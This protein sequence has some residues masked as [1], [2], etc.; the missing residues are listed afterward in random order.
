MLAADQA[1]SLRRML[2]PRTTRRIAV[3]GCEPG[4]GATTVALGLASALAM[5]G[6]RVLLVDED[7]AG[8]RATR[9]A[10]AAPR[11]TLAQVL[12]GTMTAQEAAGQ[13]GTGAPEV[14][15]GDPG[16]GGS[17]AALQG[18]RT[19]LCDARAGADGSLSPFAGD[20]H[21]IVIV[22][23]PERASLTAAY[24]CIKRLHHQY[25][26]REFQLVVNGAAGEAGVEAVVGNLGRTASQYLGVQVRF[27]G[28]MP[29]DPL[30]ARGASLGRCV[31]E[32]FP[33]APATAVL[34]RIAAGI[35]AWPLP[36]ATDVRPAAAPAASAMACQD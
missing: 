11:G 14:L 19:V 33:G 10:N 8:A 32:A 36:S 1:E 20:A 26:W 18:Y 29:A 23:Q 35:A 4:A 13:R 12:A 31:V 16:A 25:A 15:T 3:L 34:R 27:A 30:V 17:A 24:A 5:Q 21:N 28:A 7:I 6:E 22:L 9:L 2:A